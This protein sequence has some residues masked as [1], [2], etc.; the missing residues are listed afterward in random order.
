MKDLRVD[1][2]SPHKI[3]VVLAEDELPGFLI[4]WIADIQVAKERSAE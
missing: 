4:D 1:D 3:G 2:R